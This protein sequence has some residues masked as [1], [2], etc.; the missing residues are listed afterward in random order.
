MRLEGCNSDPAFPIELLPVIGGSSFFLAPAATPTWSDRYRVSTQ[1]A[2][3]KNVDME[4]AK[5]DLEEHQ[6]A[7]KRGGWLSSG[8]ASRHLP[9]HDCARTG[10]QAVHP[11]VSFHP[12]D[13]FLTD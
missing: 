5:S 10:A 6:L 9:G 1:L 7:C 2:A 3:S 8:H 11:A 12:V 4:R 13:A